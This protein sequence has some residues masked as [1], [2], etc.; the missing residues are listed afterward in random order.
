[1][2]RPIKKGDLFII[3]QMDCSEKDSY[4]EFIVIAKEDIDYSEVKKRYASQ[5]K[6][7]GSSLYSWLYENDFIENA[8]LP[9]I[10][11]V[12]N[13]EHHQIVRQK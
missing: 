7:G 5:Y 10:G 1:M 8:S 4:V 6:C 11:F 3:C 9:Q 12:A 13:Y 2:A